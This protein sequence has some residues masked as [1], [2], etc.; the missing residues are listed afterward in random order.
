MANVTTSARL[1]IPAEA[2][3]AVTA[4]NRRSM[5]A[6]LGSAH[7]GVGMRS[8]LRRLIRSDTT[9]ASIPRAWSSSTVRSAA[10]SSA[11]SSS[12]VAVFRKRSSGP[13]SVPAKTSEPRLQQR[14]SPPGPC[15]LARSCPST[16]PT[17][18]PVT[19]I[20][21]T[22]AALSASTRSR[23]T[24]ASDCRSGTAVP[25]QS[26]T[27]ASKVSSTASSVPPP[28]SGERRS[29]SVTV[30]CARAEDDRWVR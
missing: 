5:S 4:S 7:S 15:G 12:G 3:R 23:T 9:L 14:N 25:S 10:R 22:P 21:C 2:S 20:E 24:D 13:L 29:G 18:V 1:A 19:M 17:W 28:G 8:I 27:I 16:F 30:S 11:R 6:F 26:N